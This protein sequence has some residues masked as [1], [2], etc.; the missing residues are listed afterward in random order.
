MLKKGSIRIESTTNS[1]SERLMF[2]SKSNEKKIGPN[3]KN[4]LK[5]EGRVARFVNVD[6]KMEK[7][8]EAECGKKLNFLSFCPINKAERNSG[9]TWWFTEK[10]RISV[11]LKTFCFHR[12]DIRKRNLPRHSLYCRHLIN[13][14]LLLYKTTARRKF[15]DNFGSMTRHRKCCRIGYILFVFVVIFILFAYILVWIGNPALNEA[16]NEQT[17]L[18]I[19]YIKI[20]FS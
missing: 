2:A 15:V 17:S 7:R 9:K 4:R 12:F 5:N 1:T 16:F 8:T 3:E 14:T 13:N 18:M 6:L 20:I 19:K 11:Q 10:N